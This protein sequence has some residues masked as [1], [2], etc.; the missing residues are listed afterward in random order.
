[1]HRTGAAAFVLAALLIACEPASPDTPTPS[2]APTPAWSL[3]DRTPFSPIRP[4]P[5]PT[6]TQGA[7]AHAWPSPVATGSFAT[8][9][10]IPPPVE[11]IPFPSDAFNIVLLGSDR[12]T[13]ASFRTDT[14]LLVSVQSSQDGVAIVSIPRDL[15][16]YLPGLGM[17]RINTAMQYGDELKYPGGGVGLLRDTL[18]YNLGTPVQRFARVEMSG[19]VDLVDALGG[20]DVPVACP[21][22][23]WQ[24]KEHD[25]KPS[26]ASNWELHTVE[27]GIIHMDGDETLWYARSRARSSDFDR[28]RRQ[29]EVLRALHQQALRLDLIPRLPA[30]YQELQGWVTTDVS[31]DDALALAPLAAHIRRVDIRSRFIGRDQVEE[32]R[33]MSGA[34]VLLPRRDDIRLLLA[35]A[36]QFEPADQ[37]QRE[38]VPVLLRNASRHEG[39]A[40]L[41]AERLAFFGLDVTTGDDVQP[42]SDTLVLDHGSGDATTGPLLLRA[43]GLSD[44][45]LRADPDPQASQPFEVLLGAD[46]EPC[47][48]P[49]RDQPIAD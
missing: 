24:L 2:P 7:D 26:N 43:L 32:T 44:D 48:D 45:R 9:V 21:Y 30:V 1:M 46:Y 47:Y 22:T 23:D 36:F 35:D 41:A 13:S 6:A 20:V 34:A 29:Q 4:T 5:L 18:L 31:L 40:V 11:P 8:E 27:A 28:A 38:S 17:Q 49:T 25:L 42:R 10:P 39:W 19:F 33:L 16:V 15:Y 3:P 14:I 12:R 37:A